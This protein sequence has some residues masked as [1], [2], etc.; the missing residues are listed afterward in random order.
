LRKLVTRN[1][2][3]QKKGEEKISKLGF[4]DIKVANYSPPALLELE[5]FT[6]KRVVEKNW[7]QFSSVDMIVK[8]KPSTMYL[9]S[10]FLPGLIIYFTDILWTVL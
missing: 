10:L 2:F 9:F 3:F 6:G 8:F 7:K 1:T 4:M 5:E